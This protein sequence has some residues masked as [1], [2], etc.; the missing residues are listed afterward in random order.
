MGSLTG[1]SSPAMA[2][3]TNQSIYFEMDFSPG[4]EMTDHSECEVDQR[5]LS[6][7]CE[8]TLAKTPPSRAVSQPRNISLSATVTPA[9]SVSPSSATSFFPKLLRESLSKLLS[10]RARSGSTEKDNL[11]GGDSDNYNSYDDQILSLSSSTSPETEEIVKESIKN[12]LPIIPFAYPT[13][14]TTHRRQETDSKMRRKGHSRC[15]TF[16][17]RRPHPGSEV[18][19]DSE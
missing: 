8:A 16:N 1:T 3:N 10:R 17:K 18:A 6:P 4:D 11:V 2:S 12:G 19:A 13:F 9:S 15:E 7:A 5:Y 14:F